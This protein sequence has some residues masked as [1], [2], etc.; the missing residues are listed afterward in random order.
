MLTRFV[1]YCLNALLATDA[2]ARCDPRFSSMNGPKNVGVIV[3]DADLFDVGLSPCYRYNIS[4]KH[5]E[6]KGTGPRYQTV[7]DYQKY[8]VS[9]LPILVSINLILMFQP[10][11][12]LIMY[13]TL[14]HFEIIYLH[15]ILTMANL[16][17]SVLCLCRSQNM[18]D[19]KIA[20]RIRTPMRCC[21]FYSQYL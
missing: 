21:S 8:N 16:A 5:K 3:P 11:P 19:W 15:W 6:W 17:G 9:S 7:M 20:I 13:H 14:F 2:Y 4:S 10:K 18:L 1:G 12:P